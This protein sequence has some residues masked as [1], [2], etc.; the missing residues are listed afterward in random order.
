MEEILNT[1]KLPYKEEAPVV[2]MDEEPYQRLDQVL[3][4]LQVK[5]GSIREEDDEYKRKGIYNIFVFAQ[6]LADYRHANVRRT[7]T[8]VD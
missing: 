2:C 8:I 1:Y 5:P 7:R 4:P 6:P 3:R